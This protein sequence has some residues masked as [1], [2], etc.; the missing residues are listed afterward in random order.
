MGLG[1]IIG[2]ALGGSYVGMACPHYCIFSILQCKFTVL[3][4]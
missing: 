2:E 4:T 3:R 1:G